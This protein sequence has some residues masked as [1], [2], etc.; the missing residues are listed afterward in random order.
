MHPLV[1]ACRAIDVSALG[2]ALSS[3]NQTWAA[4][5]TLHLAGMS[6]LVASIT[7]FDLRLLGIAMKGVSVSRLADRLL[8]ATWGGFA[9]MVI[10]GGLMFAAQAAKYCTNWIFLAKIILIVLAGINMAVFHFT[11]YRGVSKWDQS[12]GTPLSAKLVGTFSVLLWVTVVI[13]GRWI[14]FIA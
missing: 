1:T 10:T 2:D 3:W 4:I 8:P 14:G 9:L 13:A 7:A 5:Q 12:A 11:V 6:V